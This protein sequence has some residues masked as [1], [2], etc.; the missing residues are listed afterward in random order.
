MVVLLVSSFNGRDVLLL[1]F[2]RGDL[3]IVPQPDEHEHQQKTQQYRY[4]YERVFGIPLLGYGL[5]FH[6]IKME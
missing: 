1:F 2:Q 5:L 6:P 3:Y 4:Q